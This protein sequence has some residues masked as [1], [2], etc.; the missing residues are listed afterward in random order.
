[1]HIQ[2][3]YQDEYCFVVNKPSNVV[4][5]HSKYVGDLEE[6]SLIE[7]LAKQNIVGHPVHRLDRKTSGLILFVK[8]SKNVAIFQKMFD[9][10]LIAKKYLSLVR[11]FISKEGEVDSPVKNER[12]NYRVALSR[13][14]PLHNFEWNLPVEPYQ[15]CRYTLLEFE[16][17]TGRMH[18]LRIH[19][20]KISH[21][22]IGDPKYGNRHHNHFFEEYFGYARLYLHAYSLTFIHPITDEEIKL[23]TKLPEFW[24]DLGIMNLDTLYE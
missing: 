11:G 9:D 6:E 22:I 5:H 16:P 8:D 15:T 10:K 20:N 13:F 24:N 23:K 1:M 7:L 12:G 18:Q 4:V 3:I 19:A 17:I 14:K 21:P 2:L